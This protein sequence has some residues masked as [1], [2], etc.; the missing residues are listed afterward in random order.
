MGKHDRSDSD[1]DERRRKRKREKKEK[2]R[3]HSS[4]D[5]VEQLPVPDGIDIRRITS[6]DSVIQYLLEL[7][8]DAD[9]INSLE[10]M[11]TVMDD[12]NSVDIGQLQDKR[13]QYLL[14][15]LLMESSFSN[16]SK[17]VHKSRSERHP[18][19][20]KKKTKAS[21]YSF[22]DFIAQAKS[23]KSVRGPTM[24]QSASDKLSTEERAKQLIQDYNKMYRSKSLVEEH[25]ERKQ[26]KKIKLDPKEQERQ[27]LAKKG[28]L[29]FDRE[30]DMSKGSIDSKRLNTMIRNAPQM[31]DRFSS[32]IQTTHM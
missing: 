5:E 1:D 22:A 28:Y 6:V 31:N 9:S 20:F 16:W 25:R 4:D 27:D 23:K 21:T 7:Y 14:A 17:Y 29:T 26:N 18:L 11:L 3:K 13:V 30:R 32:Q 12:G 8:P 24:P 2:K 10:Q 15:S 19:K